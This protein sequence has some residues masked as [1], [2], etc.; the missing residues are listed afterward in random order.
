MELKP[1]RPE[2]RGTC[3]EAAKKLA[4]QDPTLTV[5]RGW[6]HDT[7]WGTQEHW[8]CTTADGA[9]VDPTVEQFPTGH[10]ES[11]RSYEPYAGT[12]PCYGCGIE[13]S[14]DDHTMGCCCGACYGSVVG[15]WAGRCTCATDGTNQGES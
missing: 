3:E 14:E 10:I 7:L 6:Y 1:R 15:I 4:T 2:L 11:L 8:W 9:V 5:V 13:I 12:F